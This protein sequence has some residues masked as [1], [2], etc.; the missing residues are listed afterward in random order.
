VTTP[1]TASGPIVW[2]AAGSLVTGV[3]L[4]LWLGPRVAP[5]LVWGIAGP[6]VGAAV[7]W[8]VIA[9]TQRS[10]PERLT[11]VLIG[12][13]GVKVLFFGLYLVVMLKGL[14]LRPMPFVLSF[15]GYY[16]ALHVVEAVLLRRL[17]ASQVSS[18]SR[19]SRVS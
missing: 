18:V 6:L 11:N 1:A 5:E 8:W 12:S 19:E 2:M 15:T 4:W 16:V 14:A 9:R 7:S 17:M 10:A 13:F 3:A